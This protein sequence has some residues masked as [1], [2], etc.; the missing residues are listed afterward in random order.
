[1]RG[2][3]WDGRSVVR[4]PFAFGKV[5][6]VPAVPRAGRHFLLKVGTTG[7]AIE[8]GTLFP[9]VTIEGYDE[10]VPRD[11]LLEHYPDGNIHLSFTLP[12]RSE[13][14]RL[15]IELTTPPGKETL[16]RKTMT[17]TVAR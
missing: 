1:M 13:G 2:C 4:A 12:K 3:A 16:V 6:A 9:F 7:K 17:F 15:T 11:V 10:D 14:R 5:V 8:T